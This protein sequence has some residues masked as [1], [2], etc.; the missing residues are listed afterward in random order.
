MFN[1]NPENRW[2]QLTK[3]ITNKSRFHITYE[4][5]NSNEVHCIWLAYSTEQTV[6]SIWNLQNETRCHCHHPEGITSHSVFL[7]PSRQWRTLVTKFIQHAGITNARQAFSLWKTGILPDVPCDSILWNDMEQ[8]AQKTKVAHVLGPGIAWNHEVQQ[9]EDRTRMLWRKS[10]NSSLKR[11]R[12]MGDVKK[13][14][15]K[16]T[17]HELT[18]FR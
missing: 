5:I 6:N 14:E 8:L 2:N 15:N 13:R 12:K 1:C 11:Y 4:Q 7:Q 17:D 3:E 9:H 10:R 18:T 16:R